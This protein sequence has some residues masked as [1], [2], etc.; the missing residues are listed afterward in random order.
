MGWTLE[1]VDGEQWIRA[2]SSNGR[3]EC[4]RGPKG[5]TSGCWMPSTDFDAAKEPMK[6]TPWS[7][8]KN[9]R[10]GAWAVDERPLSYFE[11]E[12]FDADDFDW[13]GDTKPL[14][15]CRYLLRKHWK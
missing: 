14:A 8:W 9:I 15:L 13:I 7:M 10:T 1:H 2:H 3:V 12:Y 11:R 5:D 4:I 6:G